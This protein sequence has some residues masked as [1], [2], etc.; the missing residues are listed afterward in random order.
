MT[1]RSSVF[2]VI[3]VAAVPGCTSGNT[4]WTGT[5]ADSAGIEIITNTPPGVWTDASQPRVV[6]ELRIG[7]QGR[8]ADYQFGAVA[9]LDVGSDG[10]IYVFDRHSTNIRVFDAQ[11]EYLHSI[12]SRGQGPGEFSDMVV[13]LLVTP[14]DTL[15]VAD[16]SLQR[17]SRLAPDGGLISTFPIPPADGVP[18]RWVST[19]DGGVLQQSQI[20]GFEGLMNNLEPRDLL[21]SRTAQGEVLD[22]VL[23]LAIDQSTTAMLPMFD[24]ELMWTVGPDGNVYYAMTSDYSVTVRAQDGSVERIIRL[25][26]DRPLVT[27]ADQEA[28]TGLIHESLDRERVPDRVREVIL[29]NLTFAERYPAFAALMPGPDGSLWLQGVRSARDIKPGEANQQDMMVN[30]STAGMVAS[31]KWQVFGPDGHYLGEVKLPPRFRPIRSVG[32]RIYGIAW[33]ELDVQYVVRLR[34]VE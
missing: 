19:P 26:V 14:G 31:T 5:V 9:D 20:S 15:L 10:A 33:D 18:R 7:G 1:R 17:V 16:L 30:G 3:S 32:D 22:T 21:L 29:S 12:G 13:A 4:E 34:V 8:G 23:E 2:L 6:E 24:P 27:E 11:G 28:I 25:N